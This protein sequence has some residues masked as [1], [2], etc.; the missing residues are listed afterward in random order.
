MLTPCCLVILFFHK[1]LT[2][3][4]SN[5]IIRNRLTQKIVNIRAILDNIN[6]IYHVIM[7]H[8]MKVLSRKFKKIRSW[9]FKNIK[10]VEILS[11][12]RIIM[13]KV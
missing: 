1:N 13:M 5:R 3:V 6:E 8:N 2:N 11:F 4:S 10:I 9:K 12:G 7:H